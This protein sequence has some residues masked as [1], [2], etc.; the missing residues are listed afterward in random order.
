MT[1]VENGDSDPPPLVE[2]G[3][4][5]PPPHTPLKLSNIHQPTCRINPLKCDSGPNGTSHI[6]KYKSHRKIRCTALLSQKN[7]HKV[8]S[9]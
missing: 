8:C 9:Q 6:Y 2:N 1:P 4:G 3:N 5:D 7:S